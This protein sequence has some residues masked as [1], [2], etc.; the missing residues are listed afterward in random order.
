M[1]VAHLVMAARTDPPA[2]QGHTT[3][4]AEVLLVE[5][6]LVAEGLLNSSYA[7]GSYGTKAVTAYAALQRRYGYSGRDADGIP[8]ITSLTRLGKV[9]GFTVTP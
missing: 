4:R 2:A 5:R 3:Y 7:D 1:S 9:H 8:G 6:A